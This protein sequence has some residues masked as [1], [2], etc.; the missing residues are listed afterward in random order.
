M[1]RIIME[2]KFACFTRCDAKVERMSYPV[3]TPSALEGI[4][5]AVYWKPAIRYVIDKIIVFNPIRY[6]PLCQSEISDKVSLFK[7]SQ[8]ESGK[9][10][11]SL[12]Y[13]RCSTI[14]TTSV[15]LTD[16]KYGVEFHFEM[17]GQNSVEGDKNPAKHAAMLGRR[18]KFGQFT[19]APYFGC[20]DYSVE[21]L[22]LVD[23]FDFST[24]DESLVGE[25]D[26]GVMLYGLE[27]DDCDARKFLKDKKEGPDIFSPVFYHPHMVDGVIDVKKYRRKG[28]C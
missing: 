18:L 21:R 2:G 5:R 16:V 28:I 10:V 17:T 9:N 8:L 3:P 11:E 7:V 23:N 1:F 13:S 6:F 26:L 25:K 22:C 4:I 27:F 12:F 14:L 15:I 20:R 24:L 19:S